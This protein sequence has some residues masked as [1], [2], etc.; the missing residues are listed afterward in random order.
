MI[1]LKPKK[2]AGELSEGPKKPG[3]LRLEKRRN[4]A[5]DQVAPVAHP[6]LAVLV[7]VV[8][9]AEDPAADSNDILSF[10]GESSLTALFICQY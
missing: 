3:R 9:A 10:C 8:S 4:P 6:A 1:F 7:A 5:E 2:H